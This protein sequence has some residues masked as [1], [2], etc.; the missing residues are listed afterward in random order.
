[1]VQLLDGDEER[2]SA[3]SRMAWRDEAFGEDKVSSV[4]GRMPTV[5]D[6]EGVGVWRE[7]AR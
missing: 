6:F 2:E 7:V 4:I 3:A 5:L 1:M